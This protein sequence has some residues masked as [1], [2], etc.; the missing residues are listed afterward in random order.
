MIPNY[1]KESNVQENKIL[2]NP[3]AKEELVK[4]FLQ[5]LQ[6]F[7][8]DKTCDSLQKESGIQI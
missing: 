4:I 2:N 1:V 8:Y 5:T 3:K 6:N 7:G